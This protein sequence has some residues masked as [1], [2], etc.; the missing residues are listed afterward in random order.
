M[1]RMLAIIVGNVPMFC[2]GIRDSLERAGDIEVVGQASQSDEAV[3]M[4]TKL[5]P[6]V[7]IMDASTS[8]FR[9]STVAKEIKSS[10]PEIAIVCLM[11]SEGDQQIPALI[12]AGVSG[13]L[14][15]EARG[16]ELVQAVRSACAG[17]LV[18]DRRIG[19]K[20]LGSGH[21]DSRE[22]GRKKSA[23]S[24][25]DREMEI[26]RMTAR[27]MTNRELALELGV[28]ERTIKSHLSNIFSKLAA[29]S[30]TEA[31]LV[32]LKFG[33]LSLDDI[34]LRGDIQIG[35]GTPRKWNDKEFS[36]NNTMAPTESEHPAIDKSRSDTAGGSTPGDVSYSAIRHLIED[37]NEGCFLVQ[38]EKFIVVNRKMAK[39]FGYSHN[40][41]A[42]KPF[43][44]LVLPELRE[45]ILRMHRAR[46]AGKRV[47]T[48]FK[49][50][51]LRKDGTRVLVR[52]SVGVISYGAGQALVGVVS[53]TESR[54]MGEAKFRR[55]LSRVPA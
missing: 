27:G 38:A 24:L 4:V 13:L 31:V 52:F 48:H 16:G 15:R 30:R 8:E 7:V 3:A 37:I 43:I 10:R 14:L 32:G 17:E 49:L 46:L 20:L 39:M 25:T 41:L 29:G 1:G 47:P 54:T 53:S 42:G 9:A 23:D 44:Q 12:E 21:Q 51:M 11:Q 36:A 18:I 2:E 35:P 45:Q 19:H 6:D 26:L 50:T 55:W 28:R 33:F 5:A 22:R 34:R 40:E